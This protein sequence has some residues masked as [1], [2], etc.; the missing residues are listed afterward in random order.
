MHKESREMCR[1]KA[2]IMHN[3]QIAWYPKDRTR[4]R[5]NKASI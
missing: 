5:D 2:A 4:K 1:S 3:V